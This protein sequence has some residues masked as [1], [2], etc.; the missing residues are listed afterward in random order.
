MLSFELP[1]VFWLAPLPILAWLLLPEARR[2][3]LALI[4]PFYQQW[5]ALEGRQ[6]AARATAKPGLILG[7]LCW[8]LLLTAAAQPSWLGE[9]V[10]Q[11]I[12]GRE[13]LLAVDLSESMT[14]EDMQVAGQTASRI[15]AVKAVLSEFIQRRQGDKLGLILFGSQAYSHVP[16]TFDLQTLGTLLL[17]AQPGFAGKYTAIG[18]A[19][20]L[21]VKRLLDRPEQSRVIV[22]LTDGANTAGSIDPVKAAQLAATA[23]IKIYTIG[24]GANEMEIPGIFGTPLGARR[25]NPS[26]DLD[27]KSLQLI[28]DLTGGRY[29]RA[30][31][32][33]ELE[34]IYR[35]LDQLEPTGEE[36]LTFRPRAALAHWPL[37]LALLCS[38]LLGLRIAR[39]GAKLRG[40]RHE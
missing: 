1:H 6:L 10:N 12:S 35:L 30:A 11:A 33:R 31:N 29:F 28:A 34:S 3:Q 40:L 21:A 16:L 8:L 7:V 36:Q 25:I 37:A 18:D 15:D 14:I 26:A 27:E 2:R 4:V 5:Q 17:E 32:T 39:P 38:I 20:G 24:V 23:G 13:M 9:P 19:I 22:L